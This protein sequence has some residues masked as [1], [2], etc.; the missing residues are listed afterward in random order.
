MSKIRSSNWFA[1]DS[2]HEQFDK[3]KINTSNFF[4]LKDFHYQVV[5]LQW[6]CLWCYECLWI[7]HASKI[8]DS[9]IKI[10]KTHYVD[11]E[12]LSYIGCRLISRHRCPY[13]QPLHICNFGYPF[14]TRQLDCWLVS[15]TIKRFLVWFLSGVLETISEDMSSRNIRILLFVFCYC[16][17]I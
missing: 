1:F 17:S 6:D 3:W 2:A 11:S 8:E 12:L 5:I 15:L 14:E 4:S 13:I 16:N 10:L 7:L 9:H